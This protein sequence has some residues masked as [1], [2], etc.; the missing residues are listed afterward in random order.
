MQ[1]DRKPKDD[2][3]LIKALH[4][5]VASH[6]TT[7]FGGPG[8]LNVIEIITGESLSVEVDTKE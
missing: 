5:L 7:G 6:P 3:S 2:S 4:D 8:L 1:Y